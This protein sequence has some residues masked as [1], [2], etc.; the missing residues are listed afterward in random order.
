MPVS[1][2]LD[3]GPPDL[4]VRI[5]AGVFAGIALITFWL[6]RQH[7][8]PGKPVFMAAL[9][10]MML[11]LAGSAAEM[12]VTDLHCK[13]FWSGVTWPA[14]V[15][16]PT[17]W[18]LFLSDYLMGTE[19]QGHA[20]RLVVLAGVPLLLAAVVL[21]NPWHGSFY[22]PDTDLVM[23]EGRLSAR[24]DHGPL[25]FV[26]AGYL[27]LFLAAAVAMVVLALPRAP[28]SFRGFLVALLAITLVPV[29]GNLAYI[30]N[31]ST[32]FGFDP[33]PFMFAFVF[34]TFGSLLVGNRLMDVNLIAREMLF[35]QSSDPILI[36]DM[37]RQLVGANPEA[38]RVFGA[39]LPPLNRP[40][41]GDCPVSGL[42]AGATAEHPL[43]AVR[44]D[45]R[46][47]DPR[48]TVLRN[49]IARNH[50]PLGCVIALV[51]I[52]VQERI[53]AALRI[54]AEEAEATSLA[55]SQFVSTVSHELRTPLTS[56]KGSLDLLDAGAM[57]NLPP[58]AQRVVRI[59]RSNSQRLALLIDDLLDVQQI[60]QGQMR[61]RHELVDLARVV[62]DAVEANEGYARS[63]GVQLEQDCV[64]GP[65]EVMGDAQRLMQV[66]A[67][68]LSNAC[69]FSHR[70]G[71]V[72]VRLQVEGRQARVSVADRGTGIPEGARERVF[73]QFSQIDSS[74]TRRIGGSGLGMHIARRIVE[75]LGGRIDYESRLGEGTTFYVDL[76]LAG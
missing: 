33:T 31:G 66:M 47:F 75:R 68:M 24:Y 28:A 29:A 39:D 22:G 64:S 6:G 1:A 54:A 40:P 30:L 17:A 65:V 43:P 4:A 21:S 72:T 14:I 19:G 51:D 58:A 57:G 20:L 3:F 7:S 16:V 71:A 52:S 76:P 37:D 13:I 61:I 45:G 49:P 74:N 2:C 10:G 46:S 27:Y 25:F 62:R 42:C 35:Y 55:K 9:A 73:G 18:T 56:I 69:K 36:F 59:A 44:R 23:V 63:L 32:I 67:N 11:W 8:V 48:V 34:A 38:R 53:A 41:R 12:A 5:A 26:A 50:A 60:E 15:L 70:G